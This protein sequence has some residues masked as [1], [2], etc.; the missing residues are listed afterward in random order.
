[1]INK[2]TLDQAKAFLCWDRFTDLTVQLVET[3]D[4]VSYFYPPSSRST[5]IVTYRK[6]ASDFCRP[7]FRLFHET[8]HYLQFEALQK[9]G[10]ETEF[11]EIVDTPTGPPKVGFEKNSWAIGKKVLKQFIRNHGLRDSLL[12]EYDEYAKLCAQTYR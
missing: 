4:S 7:L 12:R 5:I 1:M 11:W 8:G 2:A 10:R 9:S 6:G 3:T